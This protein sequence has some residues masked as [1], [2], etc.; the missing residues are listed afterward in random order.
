MVIE[1]KVKLKQ[2]E[3]NAKWLAQDSGVTEKAISEISNGKREPSE[4]TLN[5]I[6]DSL[7][8]AI[9][10]FNKERG[11]DIREVEVYEH[12]EIIIKR[13]LQTYRLR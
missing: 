7:N 10:S 4:K 8:V 12:H 6:A 5:R 9:R 11:F 13:P 3:R 1:I 2:I